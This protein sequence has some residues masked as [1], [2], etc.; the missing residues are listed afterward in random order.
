MEQ[1]FSMLY[2]RILRPL[3]FLLPAEKAHYMSLN[4]FSAVLK[5]PGIS[6]LLKSI[7]RP[8]PNPHLQ[9]KLMGLNFKN[10]IGLAAGFDKDGRYY[11]A[12]GELG[13]GFVELGTVTPKPQKGNPQPRLFRVRKDKAIIN[14]MGFNNQGAEALRERLESGHR[15]P[16]IIGGNIGKNKVTPNENAVDDYLKGMELLHPVVD[17]FT[18]N[19]SSPNTP[20]LRDLQ[21]KE[22]LKKILGALLKFNK[23]TGN[24]KPVLLKIAPDLSEGQIDDI[25]EIVKELKLDGVV[26]TNTTVA[27]SGLRTGEGVI[28][29]IGAGGLSGAPLTDRSRQVVSY[30]R[31][32]LGSDC[33]IIGVGGIM[34]PEDAV[35]MLDSGADLIQLYSGLIYYGP[36]L[37]KDICHSL[38]GKESVLD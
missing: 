35:K 9:K 36:S 21:D 1:I 34:S 16:L 8:R 17:Y 28:E 30:L 4:L 11:R 5:I 38:D 2:K 12:L 18:I 19:M 14:R 27:R 13:F 26:A 25:I 29:N 33:V 31:R 20:N 23:S 3:M 6:R 15:G 7:Y 10:P 32:N 24:P 37:V 22:P